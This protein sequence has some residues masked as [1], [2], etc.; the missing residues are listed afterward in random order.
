[1][2]PMAGSSSH[3]ARLVNL[4][5]RTGK[6]T[7]FIKAYEAKI[8]PTALEE[9]GLRRLYLLRPVNAEDEFVAFSLWNSEKDAEKYVN[10]GHY[11]S[12]VEEVNDLL[13]SEPVVSK[14]KVRIHAVGRDIMAS[15]KTRDARLPSGISH[16]PPAV[17]SG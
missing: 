14:F 16:S 6:A 17:D 4:R 12:N 1:M 8:L 7:V 13:E 2:I 3:F 11:R 9:P 5:V 15:G 10:S